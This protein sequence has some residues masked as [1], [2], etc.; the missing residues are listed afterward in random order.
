MITWTSRKPDTRTW[1]G[2]NET[3]R[4]PQQS[5]PDGHATT[6]S[7]EQR[8]INDFELVPGGEFWEQLRILMAHR[9]FANSS[10]KRIL[11][12]IAP[13][14]I[15]FAAKPT[16][17][18]RLAGRCFLCPVKAPERAC[19]TRPLVMSCKIKASSLVE[20]SSREQTAAL[21]GALVAHL[22]TTKEYV[23]SGVFSK[24]EA[25]SVQSSG[26]YYG[27]QLARLFGVHCG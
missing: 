20:P 18:S 23:Q 13:R 16:S 9:T 14:G 4:V 17:D 5:P 6:F 7:E 15:G 10:C 12:F 24:R 22:R 25:F 26:V 21:F 8:H 11:V 1:K 27:G 19:S 2:W 3:Q